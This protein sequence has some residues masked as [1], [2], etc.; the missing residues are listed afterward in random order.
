MTDKQRNELAAWRKSLDA[1]MPERPN[2][3]YTSKRDNSK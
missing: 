2:P 1:G 3:Q